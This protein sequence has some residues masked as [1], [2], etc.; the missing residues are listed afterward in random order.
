[1][2]K[3][4][5]SSQETLITPEQLDKETSR[6]MLKRQD[7]FLDSIK[8]IVENAMQYQEQPVEVLK[9]DDIERVINAQL[10]GMI[11]KM[12]KTLALYKPKIV[13]PAPS[14]EV[15]KKWC[16]R[17]VERV[18]SWWNSRKGFCWRFGIF[19]TT[20]GAT[21]L[22]G[23]YCYRWSD[24]AW[25]RRAYDAAATVD[26]EDNPGRYYQWARETFDRKGRKAAKDKIF[27]LEDKARE[28]NGDSR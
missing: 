22:V 19:C 13:V 2:K 24:D 21:I 14:P 6:T 5:K 4:Y 1:M 10:G 28:L 23:L 9:A 7:D 12:E 17:V 11:Q 18:V 3:N 16:D 27:R 15:K 8:R 20:L 25:A 26:G